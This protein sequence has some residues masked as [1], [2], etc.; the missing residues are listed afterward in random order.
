MKN[1]VR[2]FVFGFMS[3]FFAPFVAGLDESSEKSDL[4]DS[5]GSE[6]VNLELRQAWK[7]AK[8]KRFDEAVKLLVHSVPKEGLSA[9]ELAIAG[10]IF[11]LAK[12]H[13]QH[14]QAKKTVKKGL[15]EYGQEKLVKQLKLATKY[16]FRGEYE[17]ARKIFVAMPSDMRKE[18]P[19]VYLHMQKMLLPIDLYGSKD[20]D[21][22][23]IGKLNKVNDLM[24]QK[25]LISSAPLYIDLRKTL[26]INWTDG[27][28][29]QAIEAVKAR[30]NYEK[31]KAQVLKSRKPAQENQP[32]A[33]KKS[34][35]RVSSKSSLD[36][37]N[38]A[39]AMRDTTNKKTKQ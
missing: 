8:K 32:E 24:E 36:V 29:R 28:Q 19:P 23:V 37:K 15:E 25:N 5:A 33:H 21:Q 27:L 6:E 13:K 17:A 3:V 26:L 18:L 4:A 39:E 20:E 38:K 7:L 1:R 11:A 12:E 2:C 14:T 35:K 34:E 9:D 10:K 16:Y 30:A 22:D 31:A